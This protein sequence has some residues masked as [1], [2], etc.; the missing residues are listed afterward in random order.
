[1]PLARGIGYAEYLALSSCSARSATWPPATGRARSSTSGSSPSSPRS[2]GPH[3][4][5]F[6]A[7]VVRILVEAGALED[8][9][10]LVGEAGPPRARGTGWGSRPRARS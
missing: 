1:M 10:A 5:M 2:R 3:R 9:E 4:A 8:A 6:L 7:V